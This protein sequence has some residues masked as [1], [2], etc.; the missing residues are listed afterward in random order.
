MHFIRNFLFEWT[1]LDTPFQY[2]KLILI[3]FLSLSVYQKNETG[4]V[5]GVIVLDWKHFSSAELRVEFP[6]VM[7]LFEEFRNANDSIVGE[8]EKHSEK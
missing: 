1:R 8:R 2:F 4:L 7:F 3:S 6:R 5:T